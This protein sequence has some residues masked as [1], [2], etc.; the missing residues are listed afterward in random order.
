VLIFIAASIVHCN[1]DYCNSLYS[2]LQPSLKSKCLQ[3]IQN[4][5]AC[6]VV[7]APKFS[8]THLQ[9]SVFLAQD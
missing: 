5:L 7:K 8:H 3:Q 9:I 4:C 1:L 6:I 2:L